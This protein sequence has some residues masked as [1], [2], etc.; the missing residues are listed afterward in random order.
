MPQKTLCAERSVTGWHSQ[1]RRRAEQNPS[2]KKG[3]ALFARLHHAFINPQREQ[4]AALA[5]VLGADGAVLRG[6]D[7]AAE[8]KADAKA[9]LIRVLPR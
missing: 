9:L 2:R 1:P 6:K 7:R 8:R 5:G 3:E 4:R